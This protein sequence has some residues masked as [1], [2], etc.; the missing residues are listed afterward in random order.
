MKIAT[1]SN[2][3]TACAANKSLNSGLRVAFSSGAVMGF[4]VVGLGLFHISLWYCILKVSLFD[5]G[6]FEKIENKE[7][8]ADCNSFC[9]TIKPMNIYEHIHNCRSAYG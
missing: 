3:R 2:A 6:I 1:S 9:R 5:G 4:V 7:V 8:C